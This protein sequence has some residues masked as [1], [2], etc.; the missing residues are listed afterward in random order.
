MKRLALILCLIAAPAFAADKEAE[1]KRLENY[2]SSLTTLVA[3]FNQVSPDGSLATGKFYLKRPGKMRWQY[4]P[5]TP[6]LLVSDGKTVTYYDA[7]LDQINY[8]P[9]DSTLAAFLT[10]PVIKMDS[11]ATK[12]VDFKDKDG[13]VR[14]TIIQR[15][16]PDEGALTLEMTKNPIQ[17]KQMQ[18]ADAA[19]SVTSI[20]LQNATFGPPL[21]DSLFLF[22]DPRGTKKRNRR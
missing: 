9:L 18:I 17:L 12:L 15:A 4:N 16:K 20:Q 2:L 13:I 7:E 22:T 3:D 1:I 14:A 19:G 6:I 8:V 5:P 21:Q 10:Q 11:K